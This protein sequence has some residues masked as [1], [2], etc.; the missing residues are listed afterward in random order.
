M[1]AR[2]IG[3]GAG[4]CLGIV[5]VAAGAGVLGRGVGD[6]SQPR[7]PTVAATFVGPDVPVVAENEAGSDSRADAPGVDAPVFDTPLVGP[8]RG[9]DIGLVG[10][11]GLSGRRGPLDGFGNL[12]SG[13]VVRITATGFSGDSTGSVR[14]CVAVGDLVGRCGPSV[15]IAFGYGGDGEVLFA[16]ADDG[17]CADVATVCVVRLE[18]ADHGTAMV[19]TVF[20]AAVPPPAVVVVDANRNLGVGDRISL[21]VSGLVPREVVSLEQCS[22]RTCHALVHGVA[23]DAE[24]RANAQVVIRRC[25]QRRCAVGVVGRTPL[26]ELGL[27]SAATAHYDGRRLALGLALALGLIGVAVI[28]ARRTDWTLSSGPVTV[29]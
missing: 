23:A 24:G 4:V 28:V 26:V 10:R 19:R 11:V 9:P 27:S 14:Q 2:T 7:A 20:G 16:L 18:D 12:T 25:D 3:V 21:S 1:S 17:T 29:E 13:A 5:I 6:D 22:T 8:P 15:A